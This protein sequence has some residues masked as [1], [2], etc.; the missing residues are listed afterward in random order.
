VEAAKVAWMAV[1]PFVAHGQP[2]TQDALAFGLSD[3]E[4]RPAIQPEMPDDLPHL[5]WREPPVAKSFLPNQSQQ[6]DS[7]WKRDLQWVE[8]AAAPV[9]VVREAAGTE[10]GLLASR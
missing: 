8:Y 4:N 2:C 5:V 7:C 9:P 3:F 6:H 10:V 1:A